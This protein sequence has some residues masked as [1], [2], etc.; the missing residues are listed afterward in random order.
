M[1]KGKGLEQVAPVLYRVLY[2]CWA[3]G[4]REG[5]STCTVDLRLDG[6]KRLLESK[7]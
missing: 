5:Y 2:I 4:A 3:W 7:E 6:G 1:R